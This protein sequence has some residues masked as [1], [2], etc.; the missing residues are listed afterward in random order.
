M[1]RYSEIKEFSFGT[2]SDY[3]AVVPD[4]GTSLKVEFWSG[5]NWVEDSKSPITKP[6]KFF[7]RNQQVRITPDAGGFN[8]DEDQ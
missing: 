6:E 4:S 5:V 3:R 8:I 1:G 2:L 7:S